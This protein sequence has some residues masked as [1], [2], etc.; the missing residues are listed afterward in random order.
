MA[1]KISLLEN[2]KSLPPSSN[3]P[4]FFDGLTSAQKGQYIQALGYI[5]KLSPKE[6]PTLA[7]V[8]DVIKKS[9]GVAP[10]VGTLKRDMERLA[11]LKSKQH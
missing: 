6:R 9:I 10:S 3:K 4:T 5:K 1:K 2:L 7:V 11:C 8:I